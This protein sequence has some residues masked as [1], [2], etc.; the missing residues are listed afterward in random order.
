VRFV[1]HEL[2]VYGNKPKI[3]QMQSKGQGLGTGA[4]RLQRRPL[5]T[6]WE[7]KAFAG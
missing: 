3:I 7:P 1:A 4:N 2:G 5:G 6:D